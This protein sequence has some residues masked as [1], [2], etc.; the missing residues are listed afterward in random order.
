MCVVVWLFIGRDIA[1]NWVHAVS[2]LLDCYTNTLLCCGQTTAVV[3]KDRKPV[4]VVSNCHPSTT[5]TVT[6]KNR[7]G[8]VDNISCPT[9]ISAYNRHMGGVDFTDQMKVY[10]S[11]N[12]KSKRWWIR[13]FFHFIDTAVINAFVLYLHCYKL[14]W[15]PPMKFKP[16]KQLTFRCELIDSLVNHFTCRKQKGPRTVPIVSLAPSGHKIVDMRSLGVRAG[17]CEYCC[18]GPYKTKKRKETQFGCSKCNKRLCPTDCWI[19][20][21]NKLLPQDSQKWQKHTS[22]VWFSFCVHW[23]INL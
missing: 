14:N 20:Y 22:C 17:R 7:D 19:K 4:H 18:V 2:I 1:R 8:T 21:H 6:R 12:R 15:H 5:T 9:I 13:L 16:M 11:Y 3:W 23:L 10:Y